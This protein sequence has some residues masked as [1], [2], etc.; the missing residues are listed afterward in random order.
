MLWPLNVLSDRSIDVSTGFI[1]MASQT[2]LIPS[3]PSPHFVRLSSV[4]ALVRRNISPGE[5]KVI[6]VL[7]NNDTFM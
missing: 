2:A 4:R 1:L 3:G 7:K 6:T 5:E